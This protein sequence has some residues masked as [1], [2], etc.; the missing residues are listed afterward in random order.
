MNAY[1]SGSHRQHWFK[2]KTNRHEE[3]FQGKVEVDRGAR[4][5]GE[6]RVQ[7]GKYALYNTTTVLEGQI[8]IPN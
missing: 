7:S 3:I 1:K 2:D 8:G 6:D 4:E 5:M